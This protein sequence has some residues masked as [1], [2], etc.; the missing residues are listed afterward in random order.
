[1]IFFLHVHQTLGKLIGHTQLKTALIMVFPSLEN[2]E[3]I[4]E[5]VRE[6]CDEV[7]GQAEEQMSSGGVDVMLMCGDQA[8]DR[9]SSGG[10]EVKRRLP[11]L[12]RVCRLWYEV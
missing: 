1:M 3:D 11:S 7:R 12:G 5:T 10:A 6:V 8:E 4:I 9:R 2:L